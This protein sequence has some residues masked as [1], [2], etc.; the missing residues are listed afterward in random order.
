MTDRI[1][2]K[3]PDDIS[4]L[5]KEIIDWEK[6]DKQM[7]DYSALLENFLEQNLKGTE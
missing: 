1:I 2:E 6:V 7:K 3:M 5:P 4:D